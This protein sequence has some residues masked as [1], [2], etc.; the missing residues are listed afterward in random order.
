[1]RVDFSVVGVEGAEWESELDG[2][3]EYVGL[4]EINEVNRCNI[5][6]AHYCRSSGQ[7]AAR[8]VSIWRGTN[9]LIK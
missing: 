4:P 9:G 7:L 6:V 8:M 5:L 3:R 2:S 1:M